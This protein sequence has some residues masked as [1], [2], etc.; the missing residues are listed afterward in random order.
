MDLEKY[1]LLP[2]KSFFETDEREYN[3]FRSIDFNKWKI[4]KIDGGELAYSKTIAYTDYDHY[5]HV[6]NTK[7]A[8]FALDAFLPEELKNKYLSTVQ[9]SYVQQCKMGEKFDVIKSRQND[10]SASNYK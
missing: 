8:D 1:A 6:N 3:N 7:Y 9:I 4:P 2:A 5:N 10:N